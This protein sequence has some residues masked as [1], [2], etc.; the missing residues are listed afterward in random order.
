VEALDD[1]EDA[2]EEKERDDEDKSVEQGLPPHPKGK[3]RAHAR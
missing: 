1:V 3:E 2:A